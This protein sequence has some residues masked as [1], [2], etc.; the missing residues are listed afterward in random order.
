ML[1]D[2]LDADVLAGE[3]RTQVDLEPQKCPASLSVW[4]ALGTIV[5]GNSAIT[6]GID[7]VHFD[8]VAVAR[9]DAA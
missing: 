8:A 9:Q 6:R 3:H 1:V 7:P 2:L 5:L 4:D